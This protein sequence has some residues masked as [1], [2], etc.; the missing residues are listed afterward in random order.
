MIWLAIYL[1]LP[2]GLFKLM[3]L[4]SLLWIS[5]ISTCS[6]LSFIEAANPDCK[7][8]DVPVD[9]IFALDVSGSVKAPHFDDAKN[10][11]AKF[12]TELGKVS[13]S[14]QNRVSC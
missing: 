7:I 9:V 11:T 3:A 13:F 14:G 10:F 6:S 8:A 4:P 1:N 5:K 2:I 12:V